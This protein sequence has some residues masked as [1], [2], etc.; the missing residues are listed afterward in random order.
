[1]RIIACI[2]DQRV[3]DRMLA[4]LRTRMAERGAPARG[5]PASSAP[6]TAGPA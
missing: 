2:T 6:A 4:Y 1:M 5:P 3:S